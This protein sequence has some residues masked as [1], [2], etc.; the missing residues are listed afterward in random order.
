MRFHSRVVAHILEKIGIPLSPKSNRLD[1][2]PGLFNAPKEV[3]AAYIRG[4]FDCDGSVVLRENGSSYIEFD[5]TSEKLA[6]KLQLAL[7]RFGIISHLRRRKR[8]GHRSTINGREIA[9]KHDRWEL[10]IYGENILRFA[11]EIGFNHPEKRE[12]LEKLLR[13]LEKS[14]RDTNIDVIPRVGRVIREIRRFYG[15]GP[16]EVY[17]SDT[18]VTIETKETISRRLLIRAVENLENAIRE[19]D[20]PV[21]L[22]NELRLKIGMAI[23]P[24]ELGMKPKEFYEL[25]RRENRNPRLAYSLLVKVAR[26]LSERDSKIYSELAWLLSD[27]TSRESEIREKMEFLKSLAYSD[28]PVSY[29]HLTLPT[30][31]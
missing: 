13:T 22:P 29:T 2:P 11:S 17:C 1:I 20:I 25:F 28:I 31:A 19:A 12:R 15:I 21:T 10:K 30:K 7:L 8:K 6:R 24:E 23:K 16:R 18:S 14:K 27:V 9:S 26:L 5:T 3:L 4:L